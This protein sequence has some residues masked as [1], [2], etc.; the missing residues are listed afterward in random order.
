M[1][2]QNSLYPREHG[3]ECAGERERHDGNGRR[4]QNLAG[5][6]ING[7]VPKRFAGVRIVRVVVIDDPPEAGPIVQ[8]L[9]VHRAVLAVLTV[10]G[11]D[12]SIGLLPTRL[13]ERPACDDGALGKPL[14]VDVAVLPRPLEWIL[15]GGPIERFPE[16]TH[17]D[18]S[19]MT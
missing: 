18:P 16:E 3:D 19:S 17:A 2:V 10:L 1:R 15:D 9:A 4:L 13:F 12:A 5:L 14:A 8:N 11:G 6:V 7:E